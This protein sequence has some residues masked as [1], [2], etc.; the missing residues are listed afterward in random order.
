MAIDITRGLPRQQTQPKVQ[1]RTSPIR[2]GVVREIPKE[3]KVVPEQ[4][5]DVTPDLTKYVQLGDGSFVD[6]ET[7]EQLHEDTQR[8]GK[9]VGLQAMQTSIELHRDNYNQIVKSLKPYTDKDGNINL[10]KALQDN[11]V[12]KQQLIEIFER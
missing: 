7:F 1:P 8:I 2:A 5:E 11:V 6:R 9:T 4:V 10:A 12:S 3:Q